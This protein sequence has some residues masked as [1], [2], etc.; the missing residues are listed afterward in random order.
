ML[1]MNF[2]T[3]K[4]KLSLLGT[5]SKTWLTSLFHGSVYN[6]LGLMLCHFNSFF[7]HST[8]WKVKAY[9]LLILH[10]FAWC[11]GNYFHE[12]FWTRLTKAK[13]S[14]TT[15]VNSFHLKY[16]LDKCLK[17]MSLQSRLTF[18][19]HFWNYLG[20]IWHVMNFKEA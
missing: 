20:N 7:V 8:R 9:F 10:L 19:K 4:I 14:W 18:Q 15:S 3:R 13:N 17:F 1:L 16:F 11:L 2:A 5:F 6:D 12:N